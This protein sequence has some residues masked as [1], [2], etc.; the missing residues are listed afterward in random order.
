MP[1]YFQAA[2]SSSDANRWKE[3][4]NLGKITFT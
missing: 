3:M 2:N 1:V 4:F